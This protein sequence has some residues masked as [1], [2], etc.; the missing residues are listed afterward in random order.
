MTTIEKKA[1]QIIRK[2]YEDYKDCVRYGGD[3]QFTYR[4]YQAQMDLL[5]ELFPETTNQ[6]NLERKWDSEYRKA[7][8]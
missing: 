8:Y 3:M 6:E 2:A 1:R 7:H 5:V 4:Q